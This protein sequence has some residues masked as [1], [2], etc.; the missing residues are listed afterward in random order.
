DLRPERERRPQ[1]EVP[2]L[3]GGPQRV[4]G[5][6]DPRAGRAHD[7]RGRQRVR[8]TA[9]DH[10]TGIGPVPRPQ[11]HPFRAPCGD[12]AVTPLPPTRLERQL[13]DAKPLYNPG[14]AIAE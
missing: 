11:T 2:S 3:E 13:A 5:V 8:R 14:E 7:R 1:R 6:R 4:R 9:T 12:E 10:E